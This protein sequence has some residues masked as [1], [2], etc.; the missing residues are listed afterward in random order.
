[1]ALSVLLTLG[2]GTIM[3]RF[4]NPWL[5]GI[6]DTGIVT[7]IAVPNFYL[8]LILMLI[9]SLKLDLLPISGYGTFSHYVLPVLTLSFTLFGYTTTILNDS[10]KNIRHQA[11]ILTARSKGLSPVKIFRRHI[12]R[13]AMV[14]VVPYIA[15]QLGYMIGGVVIVESL[16]SWPGMGNYLVESIQTRDVPVIQACIAFIALAFSCANLLA[17]LA[18]WFIDP[19]IRF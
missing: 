4:Q 19:R 8:A 11:F 6:L 12:L 2:L 14:P 13:N 10:V 18:L 17:D 16:F 5:Q 3:G 9:F 15:L 1:M 7:S